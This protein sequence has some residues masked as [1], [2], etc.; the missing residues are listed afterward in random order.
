MADE[1]K[2]RLDRRARKEINRRLWLWY[3]QLISDPMPARFSE[4]LS[5]QS[6]VSQDASKSPAMVQ[7]LQFVPSEIPRR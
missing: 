4:I 3:A 7:D 6:A 2:R 1:G 5:V